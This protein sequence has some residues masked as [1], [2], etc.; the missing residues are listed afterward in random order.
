MSVG[1]NVLPEARCRT[2]EMVSCAL[3]LRTKVLARESVALDKR[4]VWTK[5]LL[6]SKGLFQAAVWPTLRSAEVQ[7]VHVAVM[8][9]L[10]MVRSTPGKVDFSQVESSADVLK[11]LA[12]PAPINLLRIARLDLFIRLLVKPSPILLALL[13]TARNAKRSWVKA[14]QDDL[15]FVVRCSEKLGRLTLIT[16]AE[17]AQ[18]ILTNPMRAKKMFHA[19][20]H[21]DEANRP[22][23]WGVSKKLREIDIASPCDLCSCVFSSRQALAVHKYRKH[24]WR[25]PAR[26]F[27]RGTHCSVCLL[28]FWHRHRLLAHLM[29]KAPTCLANLQIR[30]SPLPV[31]QADALDMEARVQNRE[32]K[33]SGRRRGW[34][35]KPCVR[36]QGPL[37]PILGADTSCCHPLGVGNRWHCL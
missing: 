16:I 15:S 25:H 35:G 4:I 19:A 5:A 34:A 14:L 10:G 17:W 32:L 12:L 30:G 6:F 37:F 2:A 27:A 22:E 3:P 21:T 29:D 1:G 18:W 8:K 9:V 31:P 36:L 33:R 11:A 20:L 28:E 24:G 23:V 7:V 13:F 26:L